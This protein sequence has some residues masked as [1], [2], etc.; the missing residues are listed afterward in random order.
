MQTIA[1]DVKSAPI[2][3][4]V[5]ASGQISLGKEF[6]GAQVQVEMREP[7]VWVVKTV[8]VVPTNEL[9]LH[10]PEAQASIG[11]AVAWAAA[12]PPRESSLAEIAGVIEGE[13]KPKE[14]QSSRKSAT[15]RTG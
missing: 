11:R 2:L 4:T 1:R 3:K 5:G 9:W 10:T 7:G 15:K 14:R 8:I 13:Q 6:A 12:N